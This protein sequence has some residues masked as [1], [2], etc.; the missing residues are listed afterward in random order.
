MSNVKKTSKI[1]QKNNSDNYLLNCYNHLI[2]KKGI[3]FLLIFIE[4]AVNIFQELEI[5]I[6][7]FKLNSSINNKKLLFF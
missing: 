6:N 7:S 4:L 1:N 3:Y 5:F 2:K